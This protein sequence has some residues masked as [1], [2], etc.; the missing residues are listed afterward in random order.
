MSI[1]TNFKDSSG[2]DLGLIFMRLS[3]SEL[4]YNTEYRDMSG[5]DFSQLFMP[6]GFYFPYS[7]P[8]NYKISNGMD[9]NTIFASAN[10]PIY[11]LF[12][13]LQLH[14][15]TYMIIQIQCII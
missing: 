8:T 12:Q 7:Q 14:I 5:N 9:L 4:G 3:S 6:L 15:H 10:Q 1:T 13:F 11:C 2:N